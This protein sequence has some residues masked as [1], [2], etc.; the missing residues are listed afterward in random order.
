[1]PGNAGT[2]PLSTYN[3][4][5]TNDYLNPTNTVRFQENNKNKKQTSNKR[6]T[7]RQTNEQAPSAMNHEQ[8]TSKQSP[9]SKDH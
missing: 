5:N 3:M 9:P 7:S 1:M 4:P 6:A 8:R 2:D